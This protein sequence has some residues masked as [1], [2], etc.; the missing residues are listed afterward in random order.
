MKLSIRFP[1]M[2]L[3]L[4]APALTAQE[5]RINLGPNINSAYS[6]LQPVITS[7]DQIL[8]FTRKG[9]PENV[10]YATRKDD[11]DIWYSTRNADGSWAPAIHL[12]GPL[13]TPGYDG[14]RAVNSA[15]TH[16]YLQNQYRADGTRGKGFSISEKGA[17]GMWAYPT[18]LDIE[19]YYNDTTVAT[20]AVSYDEKVLVLSLKRKDSKV[21]HDLYVSFKTVEYSFT[22]PK[23]IDELSTTGD[24][25]AP[26]IGFDDRTMYFPSTGWGADSGAHDIF[27]VRRLDDTWLHWSKPVKLPPPINTL[28]A[29][30]YFDI[31]ASS[32]TCYPSSWHETTT[33]GFGMSDIWKV[34]LPEPYRP[35]TFIATGDYTRIPTGTQF[36]RME[37]P[38]V[39]ALL[40]LDNLYFDTDKATV[41]QDSKEPLEKLLKLMQA[42]PTLRI[43][44]QG[45]TDSD[46]SED[47]NMQLSSDRA[48][49][50]MR[51]LV[52]HGIAAPRLK[53]NGYGETMPIAPNTTSAGKQLNRR[54]MIQILGYD[55]HG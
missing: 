3:L 37:D 19:N 23:L 52:D 39:G 4:V 41:R 51:Y 27:M 55:Y 53:A 30:F 12:Q 40:R 28:S 13:N 47:H 5:A 8:F 35:G 1:L 20:L 49:T 43:E 54:V 46:G 32:D 38:A 6:D 11:E 42:Y 33:R 24:E 25:I 29:D 45:H 7:D 18:P 26:F 15:V 36:P 17:D 48:N 9:H 22:E 14:V 31:S 34:G 16:L 2:L 50:V 21:G 10:G 44:I